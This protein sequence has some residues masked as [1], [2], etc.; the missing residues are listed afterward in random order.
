R[1]K[2]KHRNVQIIGA[3]TCR[4]HEQ[5]RMCRCFRRSV[6]YLP[7]H[8]ENEELTGLGAAHGV[9]DVSEAS[10]IYQWLQVMTCTCGL[11]DDGRLL[12]LIEVGDRCFQPFVDSECAQSPRKRRFSH[13]TF[14]T[15]ARHDQGHDVG[16]SSG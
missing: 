3:G 10:N 8:V 4:L 5:M 1:E 6:G 9:R 14:L 15:H 2:Y 16:A 11:P 7:G 12:L 13:A